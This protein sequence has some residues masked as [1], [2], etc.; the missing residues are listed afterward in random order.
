MALIY[1]SLVNS[2]PSTDIRSELSN[3]PSLGDFDIDEKYIHS[4]NSHYFNVSEISKSKVTSQ[5][6]SLFH[7]TLGV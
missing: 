7:I 4:E 6:L 2:L 5:D 1:P 3:L